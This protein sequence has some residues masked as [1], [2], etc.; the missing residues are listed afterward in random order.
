MLSVHAVVAPVGS[1]AGQTWTVCWLVANLGL[2]V[3]AEPTL[4]A[5]REALCAWTALDGATMFMNAVQ[6]QYGPGSQCMAG[7]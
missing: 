2:M 3:T 1:S 7:T 4:G 6:S 5:C